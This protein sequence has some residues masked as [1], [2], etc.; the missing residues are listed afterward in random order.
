[1][2]LVTLASNVPDQK[3]PSDFNQQLTEVLAKVTGKP[4]ARISL[5]VMPGARLT[6]GGSDEPTCLINMR[7]IG[8]FSDEL[9]VKYASAIAEFM[10]KTVGIKPEKCLIEFA[11]LESQNVSCSG[12]TMKVLLA[13]Q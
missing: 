8:A 9:N 11:D 2:P 6:H 5:H 10:Q 7:A 12:T 4:A 3:F 1:M 13:K